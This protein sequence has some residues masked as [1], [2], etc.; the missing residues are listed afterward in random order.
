M[1]ACLFVAG[2]GSRLF[3]LEK[4]VVVLLLDF[5]ILSALVD[6]WKYMGK[7]RWMDGFLMF[8]IMVASYLHAYSSKR[9]FPSSGVADFFLDSLA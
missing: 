5:K 8:P 4:L 1:V 6:G 9:G 3:R 2:S 7:V